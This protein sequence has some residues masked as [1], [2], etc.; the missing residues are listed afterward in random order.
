M[1]KFTDSKKACTNLR[2]GIYAKGAKM[3]MR[4]TLDAYDTVKAGYAAMGPVF[5]DSGNRLSEL[6]DSELASTVSNAVQM[7]VKASG[8]VSMVYLD[9]PQANLEAL[10]WYAYSNKPPHIANPFLAAKK[11]LQDPEVLR[12]LI[13]EVDTEEK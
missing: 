8:N 11:R 6:P 12:G 2:Q 5:D 1:S 10:R 4:F 13:S 9:G 3:L 7:V